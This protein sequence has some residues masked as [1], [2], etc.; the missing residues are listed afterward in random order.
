[1][2]AKNRYV[3]T[4]K[5]RIALINESGKRPGASGMNFRPVFFVAIANGGK[6]R[7]HVGLS[8]RELISQRRMIKINCSGSAPDEGTMLGD[9]H[10]RCANT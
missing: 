2:V 1:M 3:G 4:W 8:E 9:S 6:K 10:H 7:V 5:L